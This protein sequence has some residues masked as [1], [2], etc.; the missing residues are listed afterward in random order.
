MDLT[1]QDTLG[2]WLLRV[3]DAGSGRASKAQ[4]LRMMEK[5]FGHLLTKD[6]R[7]LQPSTNEEKWENRTA[8]ERNNLV[9]S[10]LLQ[11]P[12][13][14]GFGVWALTKAGRVAAREAD[15]STRGR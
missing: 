15:R 8:W 7:L 3:L 10:G 14:A 11:T 5:S 2:R 9:K 1:P 12:G 4:T 6:D 13:E